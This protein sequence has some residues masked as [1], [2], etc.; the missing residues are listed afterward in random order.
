MPERE[1]GSSGLPEFKTIIAGEG[2]TLSIEGNLYAGENDKASTTILNG[3]SLMKLTISPEGGVSFEYIPRPESSYSR[4]P[5][6]DQSTD[7]GKVFIGV[8]EDDLST[9]EKLEFG[10]AMRFFRTQA[11]IG[12]VEFARRGEMDHPNISKIE[13]GNSYRTSVMRQ[14]PSILKA[15]GWEADDPRAA[16]LSAKA[17]TMPRGPRRR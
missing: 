2:F 14:L 1:S 3:K 11:D 4:I 17:Q 15:F 5:F 9:L 7:W 13:Y 10:E 12:N 6:H 8:S 16:L